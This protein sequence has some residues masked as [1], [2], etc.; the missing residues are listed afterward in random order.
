MSGE[1][2]Q[3]G[4]AGAHKE[5]SVDRPRDTPRHVDVIGGVPSGFSP[6]RW[7][8]VIVPLLLVIIGGVYLLGLWTTS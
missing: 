6:L 7:V 2:S 1:S 4:Q 8:L 5:H 3:Q